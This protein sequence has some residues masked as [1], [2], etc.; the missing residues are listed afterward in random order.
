VR[1]IAG[2]NASDDDRIFRIAEELTYVLRSRRQKNTLKREELAAS[3]VLGWAQ[4]TVSFN[5]SLVSDLSATATNPAT[6]LQLIGE[7]VG[8]PAHSKSSAFFSMADD[9][10]VLLTTIESGVVKGPEYAWILYLEQPPLGEPKPV[11][12]EARRVITEWAAA[13]GKDLKVRAKPVEV[14]TRPRLTVAA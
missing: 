13:T 14:T 1:N 2:V 6:R 7:R 4:L 9:L 8:L 5:S 11:G 3:L 12:E 10:S